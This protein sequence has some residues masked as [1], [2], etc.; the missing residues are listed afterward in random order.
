[1]L[2]AT[3]NVNSI[4]SRLEHIKSW[5][6]EI[7]PDLLCL[8]E[9]KVSDDLF[10][11]SE[12]QGEGYE[13]FI[14]GQKS[15][16]GVALISK[17]PL[18][19][20]FFGFSDVLVNDKEAIRLDDQ[21]RIISA[22]I[23]GIRI[24]NVYVP[25]GSSIDS[26]KYKYKLDWLDCLNNYI[27]NL[28]SRSEPIC[29]LGDFNIALES[30]DI[31]NPKKLSGGIMA[32]EPERSSLRK[33]I[34]EDLQDVFRIFESDTNHWSWWDYRT[35]SWERDKGWRIDHIYMSELLISNSQGCE[36][37]KN[38]RGREKPS[39]H[40]PVSVDLIWPPKESTDLGEDF[41]DFY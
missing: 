39:D 13:V 29:L 40:A 10:P 31:H 36:I 9:T 37:H 2:I 7:S 32:S 19:E 15:Y 30:R 38:E 16:N 11:K 6:R 24:V 33:I 4:R 41:S 28:K 35:R 23:E 21:K 17:K 14:H 3:W 8:Q 5:L 22:S 20:I 26:E 12:L 18:E 34:G 25:N 1:M 27:E